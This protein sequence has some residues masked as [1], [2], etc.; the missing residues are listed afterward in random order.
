MRQ[1]LEIKKQYPDA[2]LLFRVGDFYETFYEDA[3]RVSQTLGLTLTR[4]NTGSASE[5]PLA[6]FPYHALDTYLPRLVRA[7]FR[8]AI[9]EQLEEP[10]PS[11]RV[12]RRGV[13]EVISPGTAYG[14]LAEAREP[15]YVAALFPKG[16]Q[17]DDPGGLAYVDISSGE[18]RVLSDTL[19]VIVQVIGNTGIREVLCPRSLYPR[20]Q[21]QFQERLPLYAID[22][23]RYDEEAARDLLKDLFGVESLQ[24]LALDRHPEV[25]RAVG[26]LLSYLRDTGH[27]P[28]HLQLPS[29]LHLKQYMWLDPFTIRNLEVIEPLVPEGKSLFQVIDR[30]RTPMGSRRLRQWLVF[31]L[32]DL[33]AIVRRQRIIQYFLTHPEVRTAIQE[34]LKDVG[35]IER[36]LGRIGLNRAHPRL[37]VQVA[38]AFRR[39]EQILQCLVENKV[40]P[41]PGEWLRVVQ[42]FHQRTLQF[43]V[44]DPP[45]DT[46]QPGFI[47]SGVDG[48][49][50]GYRQ[51]LE[52]ARDRLLRLQEEEARRTG[53]PVKLGYNQVFG[54]YLEVSRT[55]S[56]RVPDTWIRKQTLRH[57]ERFVTPALKQLEEEIQEAEINSLQ[58]EKE[59]YEAFVQ[60]VSAKFLAVL[61]EVARLIADVDVLSSLASLALE[62][63]WCLPRFVQEKGITI[64]GG[65]H[66]VLEVTL[67]ADR[68]FVP[69]DL[70]LDSKRAQIWLITGPNMAGKSVFLRQTALIVLL[71]QVGAP[72]PADEVRLSL[73]DR[74]FC[75]VG[76]SDNIAAGASTFMVEMAETAVILNNLTERALVLLDE[77]GRG[78]STYDGLAIA[79][80][81]VEYLHDHRTRPLVLFATHYHEITEL[82]RKLPR[83]RNYTTEVEETD[84]RLVFLYRIIPGTASRSFGIEVAGMAGVPRAVLERARQLLEFLE[85][86]KRPGD[87]LPTRRLYQLQLFSVQD[88]ATEAILRELRTMNL[89]TLRPIEALIKLYEWKTRLM[90]NLSVP[91]APYDVLKA[92][93]QSSVS[94]G[95]TNSSTAPVS[96]SAPSSE[97]PEQSTT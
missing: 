87:A 71:A 51:V 97:S 6:G 14:D 40:L 81:L 68:P 46:T 95:D 25:V 15:V 79:W 78:T 92:E 64:R 93:G 72:V 60:E 67:P 53:L 96:S 48:Q 50:D 28:Q 26:A 57:V 69:N 41:I 3:E 24:G 61:Q 90:G 39:V 82:G 13:V 22:D 30:C 29:F 32:I 47:A 86:R 42:Q 84:G 36:L 11:K 85:R 70:H 31:P 27:V 59:L 4:R 2:I 89:D 74:I 52:G 94:R 35:D 76:A 63:K 66:P 37:F 54:Y 55:Y 91:K 12:V 77:I 1:Y 65:R 20:L 33:E 62:R 7:G 8:V 43:F 83:C 88:P 18:F 38:R 56:D 17:E 5:V 34:S 45:A 58:R 49:L 21:K 19:R 75:R 9:C 10:S 44:E 73:F 80:A 23:W 16:N